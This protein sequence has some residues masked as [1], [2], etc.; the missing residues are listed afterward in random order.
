[1]HLIHIIIFSLRVYEQFINNCDNVGLGAENAGISLA[2]G[3]QILKHS[4][5]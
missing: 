3:F 4:V 5:A 1:M 2:I